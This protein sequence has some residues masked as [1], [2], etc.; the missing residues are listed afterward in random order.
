MHLLQRL[1]NLA[2]LGLAIWS[3][4]YIGPLAPMREKIIVC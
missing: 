2:K 4:L 1:N 3:R